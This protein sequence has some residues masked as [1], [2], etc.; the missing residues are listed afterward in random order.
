MS[1]SRDPHTPD[2]A[3]NDAERVLSVS[4]AADYIDRHFA[5]HIDG[6]T[7]HPLVAEREIRRWLSTG[8]WPCTRTADGQLGI[9]VGDLTAIWTPREEGGAQ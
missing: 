5:A 8:V 4:E 9:T 7:T 3:A 6:I 2:V 1:H